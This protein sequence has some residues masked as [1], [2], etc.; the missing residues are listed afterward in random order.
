MVYI[1]NQELKNCISIELTLT[2]DFIKKFK[3]IFPKLLD[4]N[5]IIK[6]NINMKNYREQCP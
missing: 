2:S 3:K 6:D 5:A 1:K 4:Q